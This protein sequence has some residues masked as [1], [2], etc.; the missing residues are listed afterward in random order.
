MTFT[1]ARPW[2]KAMKAAVVARKMPPWF[3][4]DKF[5]HFSNDRRLTG[6]EI[7]TLVAWADT[8]ASEGDAKDKP[9]PRTFETGWNI[10]PDIVVEMPK[11]FQV[12][13][14]GTIDY[15]FI[16]V[17]ADFPEDMWVKAAEMRPGNPAVVHHMKGWVLPPGSRW[18]ADAVPGEAYQGREMGPNQVSDGNDIIA[19]FNPGLGAQSFDVDGGSAKFVPKGSDIVFEM[20][21]TAAGT[22]ATDRSKIGL[23]LAKAPPARRYFFS[24]GPTASNL[25]V[26]PGDANAE[27]VSEVTVGL[28]DAKL[29]YAQ[30]TCTCAARI[31]NYA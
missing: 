19:K 21:Y 30:P 5:G 13:A 11:D 3:A 31:S 2:A 17:K 24:A 15:Q 20:H 7:N 18:M 6:P 22:P 14:K 28:D 16:R 10:K 4:D 27:V 23:V 12:K 25:V 9:A 26:P 29:V 8:G 1:G